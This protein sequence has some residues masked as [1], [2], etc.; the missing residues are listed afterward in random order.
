MLASA[1]S[2]VRTFGVSA[3]SSTTVRWRRTCFVEGDLVAATDRVN[4]GRDSSGRDLVM[5]LR[6]KAAFDAVVEECGFTPTIVQGAF[7]AGNGA[8]ASAGYH[9]KSGC[10]D[11]RTSDLSG[12][13]HKSLIRCARIVGWAVWKRDAVHGGM[14]PHMHW[15][16]LG[17]HN[18]ADGARSQ[19]A[20]YRAGLDGLDSKGPD[21]HW[22]PKHV[23][24]FDYHAHLEGDMPTMKELKEDLVP[25]IVNQMMHR[26]INAKGM[27]VADALRQASMADDVRRMLDDLPN[28][29][30]KAVDDALP[31]DQDTLTRA[32]VRKAARA[33][34]ELA[35]KSVLAGA[36]LPT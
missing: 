3:P 2:G 5:T 33:G 20:D 10:I 30:A 9:D 12:S 8:A 32:E 24:V 31:A 21:Y 23:T 36:A 29:L 14:D 35:V 13:Q 27:T 26:T 1:R 17:E 11:T 15:V 25:A 34:A 22:R 28:S 6:M 19:E 18:M 4:L 7:M 16:L